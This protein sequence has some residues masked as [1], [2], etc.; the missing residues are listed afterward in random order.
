MN[1]LVSYQAPFS[2]FQY[3]LFSHQ[4][5]KSGRAKCKKCKELLVKGELRL[6][7]HTTGGPFDVTNWTHPA[8]FSLPRKLSSGANK[9]SPEDFVN[10][11]LEDSSGG[12]ILPEKADEIAAAIAAV[13][14]KKKGEGEVKSVITDL[15]DAFAERK[16]VQE[17]GEG[18]KQP[19]AKK[20]KK[21]DPILLEAFGHYHDK[22][23]GDLGD[24]LQWNRQ[25]KSGKKDYQLEKVIDG[26]VH[27]RLGRCALCTGRLKLNE[28]GAT[29]KC[30]GSF[31]EDKQ[32]R[33][34]CAFVAPA[35]E[36]PR[37]KPWYV[38]I[39]VI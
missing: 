23:G 2:L 33:I 4:F 21:V 14:P 1:L 20:H 7:A 30:N 11:L 28:G 15:R 5:A 8:C 35:A 32:I 25:F 39:P 3:D 6:G 26:H 31:D 19:D 22:K 38:Q 12:E 10:D 27:G 17:E 34:D 36:A 13:A 16:R 29:V 18:A 9:I 24:I 37:W